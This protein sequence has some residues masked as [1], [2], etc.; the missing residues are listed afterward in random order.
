MKNS[1]EIIPY[2]KVRMRDGIDL[3]VRIW[4]PTERHKPLTAIFMFTPY[5]ADEGQQYGP[6]FA[7]NGYAFVCADVRGR[8]D[9]EGEFWPLEQDGTDAAEM[10]EW[11]ASQDWCDGRVGMMGGSYRGMVQWQ[12]LMHRPAA[13][14]TIVPAASV[15]PGIDYPQPKNIF[16]S[17]AAR[18]LA[19]VSGNTL[20]A[21]MMGDEE[22]WRDIFHSMQSEGIPF[23]GLA[24]FGGVPVEVFKRWV[25]HPQYD[26]Y[27][28]AMVPAEDIYE[29]LD[30]PVLTITGHFDDDQPG[31]MHYYKNHMK[32][33]SETAKKMHYL[34]V[35]P[36]DHPGTRYPKK[37]LC[38]MQFGD[39]S[40]IEMKDLHLQWFDWVFK[41]GEKPK[42]LDDRVA[43]WVM[44]D[45]KWKYA[46]K[47][48]K[49][50]ASE[51]VLYLS[52]GEDSHDPFH[53]GSLSDKAG[54]ED[55]F[56]LLR[57]DP[58]KPVERQRYFDW[59]PV[60]YLDQKEAATGNAL[61]YHSEPFPGGLE[62]SGYCRFEAYVELDVPDADFYVNIYE[63]DN[64]GNEIFLAGD[65]M[66]ARYGDSLEKADFPCEGDV[67]LYTFRDFFF[68]SR[69]LA[70][71]SRLRLVFG[72]LNSPEYEKN[73]CSGGA[74]ESE[75]A[76]DS[77]QAELKLWFGKKYPSALYLPVSR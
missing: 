55:T 12:A 17:F 74:V 63:I 36:W 14:K 10:I 11:I 22:Y 50:A 38:G 69:K 16:Y 35:G 25:S 61:V 33:G 48:E 43:T 26:E 70:P 37:E 28:K 8:G 58:S 44:G 46:D 7:K 42:F 54:S 45:E 13:L 49:L 23:S 9:S 76:R 51:K 31:A 30:I 24:E 19:Y 29:S 47:M 68:F 64:S 27:W 40:L 21:Q 41:S 60:Y 72:F 1:I 2:S 32:Y 67:N 6:F 73:Y 75:T 59:S 71:G 53:S 39:D 15:G 56:D 20:N 66:R 4:L 65:I 52:P 34:V 5:T 57:Y 18:W 3:N 77:R 62:I